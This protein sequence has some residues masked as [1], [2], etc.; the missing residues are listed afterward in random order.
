MGVAGRESLA[1]SG[2]LGRV[3]VGVYDR[4]ERRPVSL[5]HIW[6]LAFPFRRVFV[7][8]IIDL[9]TRPL[10]DNVAIDPGSG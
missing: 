1:L 6:S 8:G 2:L 5:L 4:K 3:G 9:D 7:T 10:T